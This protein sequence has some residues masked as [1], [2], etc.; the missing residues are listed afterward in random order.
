[1]AGVTLII[2]DISENRNQTSFNLPK[3]E[4]IEALNYV[5]QKLNAGRETLA[6]SVS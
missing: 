2:K 4:M 3:F 1:M 6:K 5:L